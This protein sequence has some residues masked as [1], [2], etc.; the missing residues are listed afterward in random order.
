MKKSITFKEDKIH[1]TPRYAFEMY[2]MSSENSNIFVTNHWHDEIEI[3]YV[4]K[5]TLYININNNSYTG[6]KGDIFIVNKGEMH[7]MYGESTDL[8]YYAFIF[9]P[10][11]LSFMME[12]SAQSQFIAPFNNGYIRWV[13]YIKYNLDAIGV[14]EHIIE[15]NTELPP[16]YMLGTKASLLNFISV[17]ID[18]GLYVKGSINTDSSPKSELLKK[19]ILYI[20][21]HYSEQITLEGIAHEFNMSPK[22]FCRF[23][24]NSF[25]K[26]LIEYVN[27]VRIERAMRKITDEDSSIT[28][29]AITSGFSNMS[30]FT[31]TFKKVVGYT[32]SHYRSMQL[33]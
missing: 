23:F 2:K 32:P 30:Y 19:I 6:R 11:Y 24:K 4:K 1:G 33:K 28:E 29:I 31:R 7:E 13:H 26:T 8:Y 3:I 14:L 22:Y 10:G 18:N 15:L 5:G 21:N 16:S 20:N 9:D 25:R 27:D 12:D 17:L